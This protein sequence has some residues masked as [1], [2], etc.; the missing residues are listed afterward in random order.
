[1]RFSDLFLSIGMQYIEFAKPI[2]DTVL[3]VSKYLFLNSIVHGMIITHNKLCT[4]MICFLTNNIIQAKCN[5]T[6]TK[7]I[8]NNVGVQYMMV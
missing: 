3:C 2:L 7:S 5:L 4:R 1:M 8:F 6:L